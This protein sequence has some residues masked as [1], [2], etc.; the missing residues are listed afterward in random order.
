VGLN[1]AYMGT[2]RQLAPAVAEVVRGLKRGPL[3][4]AFAGMC[5][6]GAELST[7]R[8]VWVNDVQRFAY[9]VGAALFTSE[10]E[11]PN[12]VALADIIHEDFRAHV[13][14]LSARLARSLAAEDALLTSED[15]IEFAQRR[16]RLRTALRKEAKGLR[17]V[18]FRLFSM[19][20]ADTYFGVR[21]AIAI[22]SLVA[23]VRRAKSTARLSSDH[24]RWAN[25]ALGS[26][27]L[28]ISNSPGH[29]AQYLTPKAGTMRRFCAVRR[30]DLWE[31]FLGLVDDISPVRDASW[32]A[33]NK[34]FNKDCLDLLPLGPGAG[35]AVVYADP[36]YTDD[37]YSRFYHLLDTLILYDYPKLS[38]AGLYRERRFRTT[39]SLKSTA[40]ASLA[41]LIAAAAAGGA[42][43]VLSYPTNGLVY[44]ADGDPIEL[45]RASYPKAELAKTIQHEHST[46][47]ASKGPASSLVVEQLFVGRW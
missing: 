7:E 16:K 8:Q 14:V 12:P 38:G 3:L 29:F 37:Q 13:S 23:A 26:A 31:T 10:R 46:F 9:E 42:E 33:G 20:Y 24:A 21:Q 40:T 4:D 18:P 43:F 11:P 47:G 1:I 2:K 6:V 15:F 17:G 25:V 39:F 19:S 27:M 34:A 22:D 35:P 45:L 5:S 41:K 28:R 30:R 36:P 44:E 32:R